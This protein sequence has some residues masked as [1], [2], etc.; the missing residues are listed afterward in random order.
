MSE[1]SLQKDSYLSAYSRLETGRE[2]DGGG[3]LR[4]LREEAIARFSDLGF[5]T[6]RHEEWRH[7]SVAPIARIP[8]EPLREQPAARVT[9][10]QLSRFVS[11]VGDVCRLVVVNGRVDA[12]LSALSSLPEGIQVLSL[13]EAIR[14]HA[15]LVEP[16]LA[17]HAGQNGQPFAALNTAF[18]EDGAFLRVPEGMVVENPIFFLFITAGDEVPTVS[19]PRL[20]VVAESGSQVRIVE[21]YLG[22]RDGAYFTNAVTEIV[23]GENAVVDRYKLQEES[24]DA[25]H[26]AATHVTQARN[27][28]FSSHSISLG[29]S[30]VR[31]DLGS[32]L[33]GEGIDCNFR[34]LYLAQGNQHVDNHTSIDHARPHSQ[35][36][37]L[38]KGIL[39]DEARGVFNGRV[40]VRKD[41]QKTDARQTNKNLLLSGKCLI[42]TKPEL[43]I[44]AN[45]V[46]CAHGATIGQIQEEAIFYL[47]SRG[48]GEDEAR[49]ILTYA[50][51]NEVLDG[52]Q[53][54]AIRER[55]EAH[56][57]TRFR[58]GL[59][60]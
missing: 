48:I 36:R 24:L 6:I 5:P 32:V 38:Y 30:I 49:N 43:E 60:S 9:A 18:L 45:D 37:E 16:H 14:D 39:T 47:R 46:K 22:V 50:F 8:F 57:M 3:W 31:N 44:Y 51:A 53:I 56:L 23:V 19:Y 40:L 29:G 7:T 17:R 4:G 10:E 34:G 21:G 12:D 42:N 28:V 1:I 58:K 41:A 13:S 59:A 26:L 2:S 25:F 52:I 33:D 35:S 54:D 55:L 15:E 20:L 27:S 11:G